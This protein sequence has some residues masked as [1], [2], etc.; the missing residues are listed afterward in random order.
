MYQTPKN[1]I[2]V[3]EYINSGYKDKIYLKT[4]LGMLE[5]SH[6]RWPHTDPWAV[7][8]KVNG[9]HGQ[10]FAVHY[11]TLLYKASHTQINT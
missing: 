9:G 6:I 10:S 1:A 5:I 4:Y 7:C 2:T 3:E 8:P 11:G